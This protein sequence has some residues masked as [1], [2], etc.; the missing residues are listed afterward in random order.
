MVGDSV[1][2][3]GVDDQCL[4]DNKI[5]NILAHQLTFVQPSMSFL[6]GLEDAAQAKLDP[7]TILIDLSCSPYPRPF[8]TSIAQ[9]TTAYTSFC[10]S[11]SRLLACIAVLFASQLTTN[12]RE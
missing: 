5:R 9:P 6:L 12:G 3:L 11:N 1:N 2:C 4:L 7:E 8:K 10:K